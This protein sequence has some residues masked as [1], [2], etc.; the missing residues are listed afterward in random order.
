MHFGIEFIVGFGSG[1]AVFICSRWLDLFFKARARPL[2]RISYQRKVANGKPHS[3]VVSIEN[4]GDRP[5]GYFTADIRSKNGNFTIENTH[6]EVKTSGRGGS[7][8]VI[9]G[10]DLMPSMP[11]AVVLSLTD[12]RTTLDPPI[13]KSDSPCQ[14][15][16]EITST[17]GPFIAAPGSS[18]GFV[19][20]QVTP[21]T[22]T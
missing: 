19:E 5:A 20:I 1:L 14:F 3:V 18:A 17:T 6:G 2:L 11:A 4:T 16:G 15:V 9:S 7:C 22:S 21:P 10:K 13:V 8:T 12:S